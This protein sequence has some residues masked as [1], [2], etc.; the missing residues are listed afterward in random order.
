M[1][2]ETLQLSVGDKTG[3]YDTVVP[4][5]AV[6]EDSDGKFVLV[7]KVKGTPLGNRYYVKKV[8]VEVPARDTANSAISGDVTKWDNVVTN[9]S[10]L[11]DNGQQVRLTEKQ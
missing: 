10:K 3:R 5:N 11:L 4:N 6:K 1:P 9:A 2:G 7:V 8:K